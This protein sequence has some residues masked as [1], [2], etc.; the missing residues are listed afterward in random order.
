MV[1]QE[2]ILPPCVHHL[3]LDSLL[4]FT[5]FYTAGL[6]RTERIALRQLKLKNVK[7]VTNSITTAHTI[8]R[9]PLAHPVNKGLYQSISLLV[10]AA[11]I[12]RTFKPCI[13]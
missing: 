13:Y 6:T 4:M 5:V 2:P 9:N 10:A 7:D 3:L 8:L 1:A 11:F 12:K